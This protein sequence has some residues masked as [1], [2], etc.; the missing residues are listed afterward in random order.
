[1][2]SLGSSVWPPRLTADPLTAASYPSPRRRTTTPSA[3]LW[4]GSMS[5]VITH[6]PPGCTRRCPAGQGPDASPAPRDCG[7]CLSMVRAG[8]EGASRRAAHRSPRFSCPVCWTTRTMRWCSCC[9]AGLGSAVACPGHRARAPSHGGGHSG[10]GDGEAMLSPQ[11]SD[12]EASCFLALWLGAKF[13]ASLARQVW[14]S[15]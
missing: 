5:W 3:S 7:T 6:T 11:P 8:P 1:M 12:A 2:W 14:V 10:R 4:S 15:Q 9:R 13:T